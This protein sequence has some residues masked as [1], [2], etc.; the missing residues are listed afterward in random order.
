MDEIDRKILRTLQ[1]DS[2]I[3]NQDLAAKIGLSDLPCLRQV[4]ALEAA[5]VIR[6]YLAWSMARRWARALSLSSRCGWKC[7]PKPIQSALRRQCSD[8]RR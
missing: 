1:E 4:K 6:R 2:T 5:G 8:A 3:R 7:R